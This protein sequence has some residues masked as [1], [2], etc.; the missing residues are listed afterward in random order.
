MWALVRK[1]YGFQYASPLT[2]R[3]LTIGRYGGVGEKVPEPGDYNV[4]AGK[5]DSLMVPFAV[6]DGKV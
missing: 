4:A 1:E 2:S 3:T 5:L 6:P